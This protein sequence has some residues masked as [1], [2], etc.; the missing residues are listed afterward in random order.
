MSVMWG[1]HGC[2]HELWLFLSI[3]SSGSNKIYR[4][5]GEKFAHKI[6]NVSVAATLVVVIAWI[7]D[8]SISQVVI[9]IRNVHMTPIYFRIGADN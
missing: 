4:R 9:I 7:G 3:S 6:E 2:P 5:L 8:H 1:Y